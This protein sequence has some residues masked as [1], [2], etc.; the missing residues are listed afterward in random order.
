MHFEQANQWTVLDGNIQIVCKR[1]YIH[2]LRFSILEQQHIFVQS[3]ILDLN[4]SQS[5]TNTK[6]YKIE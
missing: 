2:R 4:A 6:H 5:V 3:R 1:R